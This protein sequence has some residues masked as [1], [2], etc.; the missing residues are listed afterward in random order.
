MKPL[1]LVKTELD[2]TNNDDNEG[3]AAANNDTNETFDEDF[4]NDEGPEED[5][6][7]D[8]DVDDEDFKEPTAIKPEVSGEDTKKKR[9]IKKRAPKTCEK[10]HKTY[11]TQT[12]FRIHQRVINTIVVLIQQVGLFFWHIFPF[13]GFLEVSG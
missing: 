5:E 13:L 3:D 9:G 10:C 2:E 11:N 1:D 8:D 12:Q 7:A 4:I 6:V